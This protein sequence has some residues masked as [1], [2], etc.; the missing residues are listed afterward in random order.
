[1]GIPTV[2]TYEILSGDDINYVGLDNFEAA[3]R[4]TEYLLSLG[5]RKIATIMGPFS[6]IRRA[7]RRLEGYISALEKNGIERRSEYILESEPTLLDGKEGAARLL[8]LDEPPTAVF[9]AGDALAMGAITEM[10]ACGLKVPGDVSIMGFDDIEF[11]GFCDPALTTIK[12]PSYEMGRLAM[13]VIV[14]SGTAN[15][16]FRQ[17]KL[18][19]D[20]VIRAS[21]APPVT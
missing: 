16:Q 21:C 7:R 20:L 11:A 17:Y 8:S 14:D 4:A 18:Q 5:H 13:K 6:G 9:C 3:Y 2:V 15:S 10:K 19:T 12:L 1:M